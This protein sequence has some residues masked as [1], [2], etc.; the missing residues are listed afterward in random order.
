MATSL[1][2]TQ[3]VLPFGR[4][5]SRTCTQP[6]RRLCT[7]SVRGA[8]D[9]K[10][11]LRRVMGGPSGP[12]AM[13]NE[14]ERAAAAYAEN[15]GAATGVVPVG[16]ACLGGLVTTWLLSAGAEVRTRTEPA[17]A[18]RPPATT[19]PS[20]RGQL[21]RELVPAVGV[22]PPAWSGVGGRGRTHPVKLAV[23]RCAV[24]GPAAGGVPVALGPLPG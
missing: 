11:L 6:G 5:G 7:S 1:S 19:M 9:G 10:G 18:S 3:P 24:A 16:D 21:V 4:V 14:L 8:P 20:R 13:L 12:S 17:V 2:R 23:P 15:P 22:R